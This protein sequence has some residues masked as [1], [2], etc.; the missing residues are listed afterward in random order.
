MKIKL[1]TLFIVNFCVQATLAQVPRFYIKN[2]VNSTPHQLQISGF[3]NERMVT[4]GP[5]T[6]HR[7]DSPK[8]IHI[9]QFWGN[10]IG[11][12]SVSNLVTHEKKL[13]ADFN[14]QDIPGVPHSYQVHLKLLIQHTAFKTPIQDM[15]FAAQANQNFY[16]DLFLRGSHLQQSGLVESKD[17]LPQS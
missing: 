14:L 12:V 17:A 6:I 3:G 2:I 1:V 11:Q 9:F 7:F 15:Q 4:I 5:K 8:E 13:A 10:M 16:F